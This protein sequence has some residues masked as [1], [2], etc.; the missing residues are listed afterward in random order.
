MTL[1]LT[2]AGVEEADETTS[3]VAAVIVELTGDQL[4]AGK[5]SAI[6]DGLSKLVSR[7]RDL[8]T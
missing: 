7:L 8:G 4:G 6:N 3:T 1:P 5:I 2:P